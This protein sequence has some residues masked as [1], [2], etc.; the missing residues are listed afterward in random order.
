MIVT[1]V[2]IMAQ[3]LVLEWAGVVVAAVRKSPYL[4]GG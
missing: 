1:L 3:C 4:L 2:R